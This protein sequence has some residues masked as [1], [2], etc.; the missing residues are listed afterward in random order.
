MNPSTA[1]ARLCFGLDFLFSFFL[2]GKS[3]GTIY[4]YF[5]CFKVFICFVPFDFLFDLLIFVT[6]DSSPFLLSGDR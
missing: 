3:F 5:L 2:C 4:I 6:K 1:D